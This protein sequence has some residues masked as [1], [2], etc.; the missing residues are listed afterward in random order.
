MVILKFNKLIRNKWVWGVFA[1]LVSIAFIAP[2]GCLGGDRRKPDSM[3]KLSK[4]EF[5]Q[6]LF[7]RCDNLV[8]SYLGIVN[9]PLSQFFSDRSADDVWKAYAAAL[10]DRKSVV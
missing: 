8:R 1:L 4:V 3:N 5:D 7:F 2:D 6:G 9:S 10:S